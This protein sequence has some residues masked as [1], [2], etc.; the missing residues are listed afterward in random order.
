MDIVGDRRFVEVPGAKTHEL[1][2]LLVKTVPDVKRLDKMMC[3]AAE[4]IEQEDMVPSVAGDQI[5]GEEL[6]ERRKMDLALNLVDQYLGL[7]SHWHWGDAVIEWIRQCEI[8]FGMRI[9]LKNLLRSEV[10]PHAG[11]SSFVTLLEDKAVK[12]QGVQLAKAVGLRLAFR[13]MPPIRCCSDQFLFYLNNSVAQTAYR[14]WL[15][16]TPSPISSLPP[17]RFRFDVVNM[18]LEVH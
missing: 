15:N 1:P 10:W 6:V 18:S 13:Q 8:T 14:T 4:I 16:M 17:E 3:I 12:T 5:A 2:P 7:L 9:E 11:R